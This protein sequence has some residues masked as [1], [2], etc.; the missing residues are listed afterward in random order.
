MKEKMIKN[1]SVKIQCY[2]K[3]FAFQSYQPEK[4]HLKRYNTDGE[5]LRFL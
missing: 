5:E 4:Y 1:V 2:Q 3:W